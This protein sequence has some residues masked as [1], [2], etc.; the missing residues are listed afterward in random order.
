[1][2]PATASTAL[3]RS[4]EHLW[5]QSG[6]TTLCHRTSKPEV[7]LQLASIARWLGASEASPMESLQWRLQSAFMI[8]I[9]L[10]YSPKSF[11]Y[12]FVNSINGTIGLLQATDHGFRSFS[13]RWA[14]A[15][16]ARFRG[17]LQSAV[18]LENSREKAIQ[19]DSEEFR[20]L[21]TGR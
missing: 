6:T 5:K 12:L 17:T 2:C 8:K 18:R 14:F 11:G 10:K 13:S 16:L 4:W 1:M 3:Q 9:Y 15:C 19:R 7:L 21:S 20:R